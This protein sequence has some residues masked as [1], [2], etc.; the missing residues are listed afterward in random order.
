VKFLQNNIDGERKVADNVLTMS[1]RST[2]ESVMFYD[3]EFLMSARL[4]PRLFLEKRGHG[5]DPD[6]RAE[7]CLT[8]VRYIDVADTGRAMMK[9]RHLSRDSEILC[10]C[11]CNKNS[12]IFATCHRESINIWSWFGTDRSDNQSEK[13]AV[14]CDSM[15]VRPDEKEIMYAMALLSHVPEWIAEQDAHVLLQLTGKPHRPWLT[16]KIVAVGRT[17]HRTI[18]SRHIGLDGS[19]LEAARAGHMVFQISQSERILV[20]AGKGVA[21]FFEIVKIPTSSGEDMSLSVVDRSKMETLN[22]L[23]FCSCLCLPPPNNCASST[24]W[25]ILGDSSGDLFGFLIESSDN[26]GRVMMSKHHGRFSSKETK[27]DRDVPIS[28]LIPTFGSSPDSHHRHMKATGDPYTIFLE[29]KAAYEKDRFFSMGDN[30]KLLSWTLGKRGWTAQVEDGIYDLLEQ[31]C[32]SLPAGGRQFL[33]AH[34]SRLIPHVLVAM[35]H[36]NGKL[37]CLD[38]LNMNKERTPTEAMC[39]IGGA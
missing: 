9:K 1:Q 34:S 12:Q 11:Q 8:D 26:S 5:I 29:Q 2:T 35:D 37:I 38:T 27:H 32:P 7:G 36:K 3:G 25:I 16:I 22:D 31:G 10:M 17:W 39:S 18:Y 14:V 6:R 33:A 15:L 13:M 23:N 24:D 20:L 28:L 21:L 19:L 4:D 30:G